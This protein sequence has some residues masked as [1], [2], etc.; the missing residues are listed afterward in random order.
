MN[1]W[2][3]SY[4][5]QLL[6]RRRRIFCQVAIAVMGAAALVTALWP[7]TYESSAQ[8]LVGQ[9]RAQ[10]LVSPD[11][12]G[13]GSGAVTAAA[14][15]AVSQEDLNSEV[16]LLTSL[17]L[18][19]AAVK[20][21]PAERSSGGLEALLLAPAK[22][23]TTLPA[24]VYGIL[25]RVHAL[26]R[27]DSWVL[28]L[29]RHLDP[30]VIKR[31]NV[32]EIRYSSHDADWSREFLSRLI[33][34]YLEYH[35]RLSHA[36]QAQVFF[37]NQALQFKS[38]LETSEKNLRDFELSNGIADLPEQKRALINQQSELQLEYK[39]TAVQLS[40]ARQQVASL[41]SQL[42]ATPQRTEN[43]T[44]SVQ[45]IALAQLKPQL[46][47]LKA[48]RAELL[49]RYQPNSI[50]I[51]E[52]DAKLAEAQKIL[53]GEDHL[54]VQERSTEL[55]PI[56]ITID[57]NLAAAKAAVAAYE[58]GQVDLA[59][60]IQ[61]GQ[62]HVAQLINDEGELKR[63]QRQA[64]TD[65]DTYLGY[66]RASEQSRVADAL[67]ASS[68]LNVS[69]S[70]PPLRPLKPTLPIVWLNLVVGFLLAIGLGVAAA[71]WEEERDPKLYTT[72]AIFRASGL[73][74]IAV[75]RDQM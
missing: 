60:Q 16:E 24:R 49:S 52:I 74:T 21:V 32:I 62:E 35:G 1:E 25:H 58:A 75:L 73:N 39:K 15:N 50:K 57:T 53:D 19:R 11:V 4:W 22:L 55:N 28:D 9:D 42:R 64:Q 31:S 66:S 5:L 14:A 8:I 13:G 69:V 48:E 30:E 51:R 54:E 63:L 67:N 59:T 26:S 2:R 7:P 18:I 45:N 23:M 10:L 20:D 6:A 38:Q 34:Q 27:Q 46:M 3:P 43:Q 29:Q 37:K 47:Q 36:P 44:K 72:A 33:T 71:Y 70:Q 65:S 41:E 68:I 56:W 17:D 61:K 12:Q 40:S